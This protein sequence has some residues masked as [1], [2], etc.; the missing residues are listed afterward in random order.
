MSFTSNKFLPVKN[1]FATI[2]NG[3]LVSKL[4]QLSIDDLISLSIVC[5]V[6]SIYNVRKYRMT[7]LGKSVEVRAHYPI[8]TIIVSYSFTTTLN[9]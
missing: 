9:V 1:I 2:V 7:K 4:F 3:L 6:Y 8:D 5:I